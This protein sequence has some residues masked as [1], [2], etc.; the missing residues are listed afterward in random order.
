M[1]TP[2]VLLGLLAASIATSGQAAE[3]VYKWKDAAG[4]T[5]FSDAPP[6]KGT[7]FENVQVK[8]E[9]PIAT[10][11]NGASAE[12]NAGEKKAQE[13]AGTADPNKPASGD[14]GPCEQARNRLVLLESKSELN[15]I[16]NGKTVPMTPQMRA[17][18]LNVAR[19]QVQSYCNGTAAPAS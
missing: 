4:V 2:I 6:P 9:A 17:A 10:A 5:H 16:E 11:D 3:K 7:Q 15:T 13:Q 12:A 1:K 8:G 18:E 19:A 14:K